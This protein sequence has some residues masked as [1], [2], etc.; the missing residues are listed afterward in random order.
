MAT[1]TLVAPFLTDDPMFSFGVEYGLLYA[2]MQ[3]P[4]SEEITDFFCRAN[5]D[6]ILLLASRLGWQMMAMKPLDKHWFW[7]HLTKKGGPSAGLEE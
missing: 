4:D 7:C 1:E 3:T 6:R 5:Q 2:R